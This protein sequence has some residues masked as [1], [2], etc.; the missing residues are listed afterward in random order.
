M[1]KAAIQLSPSFRSRL[2]SKTSL[3]LPSLPEVEPVK[4]VVQSPWLSQPP[5][6]GKV[7]PFRAAPSNHKVVEV[8]Q[9]EE[10]AEAEA[11]A[12]QGQPPT[13]LKET[14]QQNRLLA[15]E[16]LKGKQ[17]D[18]KSQFIATLIRTDKVSGCTETVHVTLPASTVT[19][20]HCETSSLVK[21]SSTA[22]HSNTWKA[23]SSSS[24]WTTLNASQS[25]A[26]SRSASA[27]QCTA[28]AS[29]S[30]FSQCMAKA[31]SQVQ[32]VCAPRATGSLL[33][34]S[35]EGTAASASASST[36]QPNVL[37]ASSGGVS[38]LVS[39]SVWALVAPIF[40]LTGFML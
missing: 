32:D 38:R 15:A 25:A 35:A 36:A 10:E 13:P 4:R 33:S 6:L 31:S 5:H 1:C 3:R 29:S 14:E 17:P 27:S 16:S 39:S 21:A 2:L 22:P 18:G 28:S 7:K 20:Y 9:V 26:S 40:I 24:S 8:V 23:E 34:S 30:V 37:G 11:E 19:V 12:D